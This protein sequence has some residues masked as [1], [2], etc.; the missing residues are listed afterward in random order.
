MGNSINQ[1]VKHCL[2]IAFVA[3]VTVAIIALNLGHMLVSVALLYLLAVFLISLY[4]GRSAAVVASLL[5]FAAFD[6][7]FVEPTHTLAVKSI[8]EWIALCIFLFVATVTGQLTARLKTAAIEA[9]QRQIET[10]T[11][12][13]ASWAVSSQPSTEEA[14]TEVLNQLTRVADVETAA[15]ITFDD[16]GA[17]VLR[18]TVGTRPDSSGENLLA[19]IDRHLASPQN[20]SPSEIWTTISHSHLHAGAVYVKLIDGTIEKA[21]PKPIIN[22]LINHALVILQ[23]EEL[24]KEKSRAQ[25]LGEADKLKTALLSMVSHDFKS[26]LTGIK[27]AVGALLQEPQPRGLEGDDVKA[28][29]QGIEQEADRINRMVGNILNLSRLEA[30]AWKPH[31]ESSSLAELLGSSLGSFTSEE[32]HRITVKMPESMEDIVIDPVQIEQVLKNLI[33]NAL[34]YSPS[35][36]TVEIE[37]K[38]TETTVII[39]VSDRGAGIAAED[40]PYIF[41]RFYRRAGLNESATPGAGIGLAICKGLVEAHRGTLEAIDRAGGGTI[42][43]IELPRQ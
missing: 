1:I 16:A 30:D 42:F 13:K 32:N 36:S 31:L 24:F 11:L 2:A 34:K 14:L 26:P 15:V 40:K 17:V 23:R 5:S 12:A 29:L 35:D 38:T 22:T 19:I 20:I 37:I 43:E 41:D 27:T 6:W 21:Q 4:V 25:A 3:A 9:E 28:L 8:S 33:E 18:A 7:F 10:E 39:S